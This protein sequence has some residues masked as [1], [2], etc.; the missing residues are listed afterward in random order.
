MRTHCCCCCCRCWDVIVVYI[1]LCVDFVSAVYT[2]AKRQ[3]GWWLKSW[4]IIQLIFPCLFSAFD[5]FYL[6][7]VRR[8]FALYYVKFILTIVCWERIY[9]TLLLF[10]FLACWMF[11]VAY[12]NCVPWID[13]HINLEEHIKKG[14]SIHNLFGSLIHLWVKRRKHSICSF[15]R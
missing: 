10:W 12:W 13:W 9:F 15:T 5:S 14:Q 1:S 11:L 6:V 3:R 4:S 2:K 8:R 7:C